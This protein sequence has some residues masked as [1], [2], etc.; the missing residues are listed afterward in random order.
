VITGPEPER[1]GRF[2]EHTRFG[3]R[4]G[5]PRPPVLVVRVRALLVACLLAF[6]STGCLSVMRDYDGHR[7]FNP[8][9]LF[10]LESEERAAWQKPDEV[11]QALALPPGACVADIGA[12]GGYFTE[13]FS[14]VVGD[15]GRV[16]ATDVQPVLLRKLEK[17]VAK[18]S[19]TNVTV[20][21]AAFDDPTLPERSCDLAF[22]SSVYK[23][24]DG[25]VEYMQ[26]LRRALKAGGRVA[27]LEYRPGADARGPQKKDRLAESQVLQEMAAA[28]YRLTERFDFLPREYFLVFQVAEPAQ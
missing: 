9:Y 25:R 19:L 10:Y 8:I 20:I 15:S 7:V 13:R 3:C 18:Q 6:T 16:F 23:E 14:R 11:I 24:I 12:G 26:R 22:L 27:V 5:R 1:G 21:H 2:G 28:G 17:R 4:G